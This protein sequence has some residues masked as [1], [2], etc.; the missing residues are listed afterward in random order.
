MSKKPGSF[1]VAW[2]HALASEE[3]P[4]KS[5]DRHVALT[6]SLHL[7]TEGL[8]AWPSQDTVALRTGLTDRTVGRALKRLCDS[9]WFSRQERKAHDKA[10]RPLPHGKRHWRWGFEYRACLPKSLLAAYVKGE[11][12]SL[13]TGKTPRPRNGEPDDTAIANAVRT[14]AAIELSTKPLLIDKKDLPLTESAREVRKRRAER[15]DWVRDYEAT[16][17]PDSGTQARRDQAKAKRA[18]LIA[19]A[20]QYRRA[21]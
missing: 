2:R 3:G 7:S 11:R 8:G 12:R 20:Q 19:L 18:S 1:L 6:L 13:F 21:Q 14:N 16:D 15:D 4:P 5:V 9:G 10:G 17:Q